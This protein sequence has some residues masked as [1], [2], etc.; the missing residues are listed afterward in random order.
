MTLTL[1][2]DLDIQSSAGYGKDLFACKVQCQRSLGSEDKVETNG[3]T[4]GGDSITSHANAVN[5][6][7]V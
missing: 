6:V 7:I 4:D 3:R 5:Y 1:T 2:Y